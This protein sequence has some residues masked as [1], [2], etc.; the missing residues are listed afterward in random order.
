MPAFADH[1]SVTQ[2]LV[3]SAND[4]FGVNAASTRALADALRAVGILP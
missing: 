3:R 4:L 2:S 1:A